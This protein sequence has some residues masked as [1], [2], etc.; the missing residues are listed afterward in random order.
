MCGISGIINKNSKPVSYDQIKKINDLIKHRGPDDEGYYFG[1]NFAFGHRR[2][3]IIDLS[4]AG[5]QPMSYKDK[6]VIIYNGEVYN[7]VELKSELLNYGYDFQTKTDTEVILAAYDK[8]GSDCVNRFNGM[9]AFALYNKE[10]NYIFCSR[11]RFGIKPFYYAQTGE[12]FIFGSEIKQLLEYFPH[13]YVN[14]SI[15]ID[16]LV[17]GFLEHTDQTFFKNIFKLN[18]ACNLIYD[19]NNNEFKQVRYYKINLDFEIS[20]KDEETSVS[21]YKKE[22]ERAIRIRLRSDVKVGTC[23]SG[24]IDS[25]SVATLAS[26][27]YSK[28]SAEKFNA[29]TAKSIDQNFD[30][31]HFAKIVVDNADLSWNYIEPTSE[32]FR[33]SLNEV[34]Y[35]QEEPFGSPSIFM[36]YFVMKKAKEIGCTVMLDGQGGDE[37]LLGYEKYYPAAYLEYYREYG[38][39]KTLR[40]IRNSNKNNAKMSLKWIIF[41]IIGTLF[42]RLRKLEHVRRCFFVKKQYLNRFVFLDELAQRYLNINRLQIF[43]I[44]KT[45]LPVLLRYEDRNSMRHSIETRLPYIDYLTLETALSLNIKYKIKDGW[46]KYVLRK[47]LQEKIPDEVIW[48]KN[49]FGF[50][51]PESVWID[52]YK[53]EMMRI[54][55]NSEILEKICKKDKIIKKFGKIDYKLKWRIFNIAKWE[56]IFNVELK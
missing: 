38:F 11:D 54:I 26:Q 43:E 21:I 29:I 13:R 7:Y 52:S 4:E 53:E 1:E 34:V 32:D 9:W 8:W 39:V 51:A 28:D 44:E 24:G 18:P 42:S 15:V 35:T 33:Q 49:K 23:L 20:Q 16:Y 22:L 5:H 45:N 46:S 3:S 25:S 19:L 6:Y 27:F 10:K 12:K 56:E 14:E 41:Y 40:E 48:R 31:S 17:T 37:T 2:L 30:E 50:N 55:N 47:A 36:Q